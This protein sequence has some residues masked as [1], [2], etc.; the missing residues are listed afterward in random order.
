MRA[1][2]SSIWG[3][4]SPPARRIHAG[5][6][7]SA[8]DMYWAR[9]IRHVFS[10]SSGTA[11]YACTT[12]ATSSAGAATGTQLSFAAAS[13]SGRRPVGSPAAAGGSDVT[14]ASMLRQKCH[15]AATVETIAHSSTNGSSPISVDTL[16]YTSR[17]IVPAWRV[18]R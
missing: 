3:R 14:G 9:A 8:S 7:M 1:A 4:D 17:V 11:V 6:T 10:Y 15:T 12:A 5:S 2:T 13:D 16:S 18:S